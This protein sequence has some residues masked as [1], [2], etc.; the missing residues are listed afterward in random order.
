ML[1]LSKQDLIRMKLEFAECYD[2]L[3]TKSFQALQKTMIV[4]L[5]AM[6]KGSRAYED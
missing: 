4:K 3:F 1:S 2:D 6:E 5:N